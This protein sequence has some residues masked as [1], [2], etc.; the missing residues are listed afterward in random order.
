MTPS[1]RRVV[2]VGRVYTCT[3]IHSIYMCISTCHY[4]Y[5]TNVCRFRTDICVYIWQ[6]YIHIYIRTYSTCV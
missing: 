3:Y 6:V 1:G 5:R 2:V 4:I